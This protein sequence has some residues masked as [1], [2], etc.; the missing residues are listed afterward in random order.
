M[1]AQIRE[2]AYFL[3][4]SLNEIYVFSADDLKFQ[5]ANSTALQNIGYEKETLQTM[6]PLEIKPEYEKENFIELLQPLLTGKKENI[7]FQTIHRRKDGSDYPV[8]VNMQ[9]VKQE[10]KSVFL[11]VANDVTKKTGSRKCLE[12]K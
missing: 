7:Q 3:E 4:V 12:R 2:L 10:G 1:E 5:Y 8:E 11:V 6:T 9:L